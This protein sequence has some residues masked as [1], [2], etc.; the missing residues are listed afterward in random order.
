MSSARLLVAGSVV[1]VLAIGGCTKRN[2]AVCCITEADCADFGFPFPTPCEGGLACDGTSCVEP[3]CSRP[4]DCI[5]PTLPYC[6]DGICLACDSEGDL[7]CPAE[8]PVCDSAFG[9]CGP[10]TGAEDCASHAGTPLCIEGAC[11]ACD[12]NDDCEGPVPICDDGAC[13]ACRVDSECATGACDFDTGACVEADRIIYVDPEGTDIGTCD[14]SQPCASLAF[15]AQQLTDNR[16]HIVLAA[17]EYELPTTQ[18]TVVALNAGQRAT[19]HGTGATLNAHMSP[20]ADPG[21]VLR[22]RGATLTVVGLT[23][24]QTEGMAYAGAFSCSEAGGLSLIRVQTDLVYPSVLANSCT[25]RI[26]QSSLAT[27]REDIAVSEAITANGGTIEITRSRLERGILRAT[28]VAMTLTNDLVLSGIRISASTGTASF[29]TLTETFLGDGVARALLC[30]GAPSTPEF[31][32]NVI[33]VTSGT[34]E[35]IVAGTCSVHDNLLGPT[36]RSDF[37]NFSADPEFVNSGGDNFHLR[38]TSPAVDQATTGP[39]VDFDGDPRPAG[40]GWDLGFD[41]TDG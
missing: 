13:R 7:G 6:V 33:W 16:S 8:T 21:A 11:V 27:Y 26:D 28:G 23:I 39:S 12:E 9:T 41:E 35:A 14:A 34:S 24:R 1:A 17:G 25:V 4:A 31:H 2:P 38:P 15:A 19:F 22:S 3:L 40:G 18:F 20:A 5:D 36:E 32:S 10:C 30:S 29:N 37:G